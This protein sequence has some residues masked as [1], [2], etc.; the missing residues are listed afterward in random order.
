[1]A[2]DPL[3]R[4][5]G[6][7]V[8]A[9]RQQLALL[10]SGGLVA[11]RRAPAG[12][13]R[14]RHLFSLT[15]A[16]DALFPRRQGELA[17]ELLGHLEGES[18][19]LLDRVFDLRARRRVEQARARLEGLPDLRSRVLALATILDEDGYLARVESLD[20]GGFLLVEGNCAVLDIAQRYRKACSSEIDFLREVL[21]DATV[22]R[23]SHIVQGD[24]S[25]AYRIHPHPPAS[26]QESS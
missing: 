22:Q 17:V 4:A 3:A 23:V 19:E 13:G 14:P 12:P 20:D 10:E 11:H 7:T 8:S 16:G 1:M 15:P 18:P 5:L 6:I 26:P 21:S 24:R 2:A 25:C 9:A